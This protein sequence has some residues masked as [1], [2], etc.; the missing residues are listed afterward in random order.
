MSLKTLL[1]GGTAVTQPTSPQE[2]LTKGNRLMFTSHD[3]CSIQ[4]RAIRGI[5]K[6][7]LLIYLIS[8]SL[9]PKS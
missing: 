1:F 2:H 8:R 9:A 3:I 6:E 7:S 4:K 5:K